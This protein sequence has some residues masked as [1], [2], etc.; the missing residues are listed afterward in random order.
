[1]KLVL[2]ILCC[3]SLTFCLLGQ[4]LYILHTSIRLHFFNSTLYYRLESESCS[5]ISL[6]HKSLDLSLI[7]HLL[8]S[9]CLTSCSLGSN[10]SNNHIQPESSIECAWNPHHT[11]ISYQIQNT[12]ITISIRTFIILLPFIETTHKQ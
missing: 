1:M 2:L 12:S 3:F 4:L 9:S 10:H 7:F 8:S 5:I 6:I 11:T